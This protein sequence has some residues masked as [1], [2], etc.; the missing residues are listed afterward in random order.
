[1]R[2]L[3]RGEYGCLHTYLPCGLAGRH[4]ILLYL[5]HCACS[6]KLFPDLNLLQL[7]NDHLTIS[8]FALK[9]WNKLSW[10]FGDVILSVISNRLVAWFSPGDYNTNL[11][12]AGLGMLEIGARQLN[13]WRSHEPPDVLPFYQPGV[14][15][16]TP[17]LLLAAT[18]SI[19]TTWAVQEIIGKNTWKIGENCIIIIKR[20]TRSLQLQLH[21]KRRRKL[22]R[23]IQNKVH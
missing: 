1:M 18:S 21:M 9:A 6:G 2:S 3:L 23:I 11:V 20:H 13:D 22:Q 7:G 15:F 8:S 12:T 5:L 14:P 16:N 17:I 10:S 19:P 4:Y